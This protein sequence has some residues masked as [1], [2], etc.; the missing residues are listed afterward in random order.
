MSLI[1]WKESNLF[2]AF[3]SLWDNFFQKGLE[4]G[5]SIPAMN[6]SETEKEYQ[7][8]IAVPGLKKDDFKINLE[9]NI[10]SIS[11]ETKTETEEKDGEKVT[12]REFNY[13]SFQRSFS[14]PEN[15]DKDQISAEY[16]DGILKLH[17]PKTSPTQ[18]EKK[19]QIEIK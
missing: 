4:L 12:K 7:V 2:P 17:I 10:L 14:L 15:V 18:V 13:S 9:H 5:T 11:S 6:T 8:E 3:N 1:K 19:K 16:I